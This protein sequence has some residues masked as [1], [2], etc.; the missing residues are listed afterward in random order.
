MIYLQA[1]NVIALYYHS[2]C[3]SLIMNLLRICPPFPICI[4]FISIFSL[5][6]VTRTF[7]TTLSKSNKSGHSYVVPDLRRN[8]FKFSPLSM[9]L[10]V[11]LS[12]MTFLLCWCIFPL[13]PLSKKFFFY[14]KYV[15]NFIES[16]FSI[17]W[18]DHMVCTL[19]FVNVV[20]HIDW[21]VDIANDATGKELISK[22]T[23]SS[24]NL[25]LKNKQ[26][27]QKIGRTPK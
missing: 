8:A 25:I 10:A 22:I 2:V 9:M 13:C 14:H 5:I 4:P 11:D 26:P 1:S 12:Y 18:D 16:F 27:N 23:N 24:Y 15:L 6:A 19:Q 21:F 3:H 20:Y 17:Y 7:R